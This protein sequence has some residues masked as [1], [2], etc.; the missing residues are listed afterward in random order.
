NCQDPTKSASRKERLRMSEEQGDIE[1]AAARLVINSLE[2]HSENARELSLEDTP[3]RIPPT[4]RLGPVNEPQSAFNRLGPRGSPTERDTLPQSEQP[5][6]RK[7]ASMPPIRHITPLSLAMVNAGIRK[8]KAARAAKISKTIPRNEKN[9]S[10]IA[11]YGVARGELAI[12]WKEWLQLDIISSCNNYFDTRISYEGNFSYAT[13]Y[14]R[15]DSSDHRPIITFFE[16]LRRK[17][18]GTFRYNR[19]LNKNPQVVK[20]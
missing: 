17:K 4:Q 1:K 12:L 6:Q 18:R 10:K 2:I 16:P 9:N 15:F 19:S 13:F 3:D 11:P 7:K 20:L 5:A 8:R 14:L